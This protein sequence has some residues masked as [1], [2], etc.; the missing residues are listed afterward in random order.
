[1][2]VAIGMIGLNL[3][4]PGG[5]LL[6]AEWS[7]QHF[8]K[9]FWGEDNLVTW[10]SSVQLLLIAGVAYLVF[11]VSVSA[12]V[13]SKWCW[14][15]LS[16]GFVFLALDERFEIHENL[17]D[18]VF[19]PAD[20]F[21]D[22]PKLQAGDAGLFLYFGVGLIVAV[23]LWR[24]L[25]D[26]PWAARLFSA[27]LILTAVVLVI[28]GMGWPE[29]RHWPMRRFWTSVFEETGELWAQLL[30]LLSFLIVLA[31]RAGALH[32]VRDGAG[33]PKE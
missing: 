4:V 3:L 28:D 2:H 7:G 25:R 15:L 29:V 6:Y 21:T 18:R 14:A 33:H 5:I 9:L 1:M 13:G 20:L 27:A 22:I 24:E 8:S 12:K 17:R 19:I 11:E 23:F 16:L 10:F 31:G 26:W 32:T 30:F